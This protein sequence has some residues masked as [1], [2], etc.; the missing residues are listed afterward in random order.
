MR[1]GAV[2]RTY[3]IMFS[4]NEPLIAIVSARHRWI[5][6]IATDQCVYSHWAS[7]T[8]ADNPQP[9]PCL[10][11]SIRSESASRA[12]ATHYRNDVFLGICHLTILCCSEESC[13]GV[14]LRVCSG[15]ELNQPP[16][17]ELDANLFGDIHELLPL[18]NLSSGVSTDNG[19]IIVIRDLRSD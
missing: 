12:E 18:H 3:F 2:N 4:A 15:E 11:R 7:P 19:R 5:M 6:E 9:R 16:H 1:K 10:L 14:E 13:D 17:E 8:H